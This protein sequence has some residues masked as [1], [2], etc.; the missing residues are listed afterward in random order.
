MAKGKRIQKVGTSTNKNS[1][2]IKRQVGFMKRW[3]L[4]PIENN[5]STF[6]NRIIVILSSAFLSYNMS[7]IESELFYIIG[8]PYLE[9]KY[10]NMFFS[11]HDTDLYQF[12]NKL[13]ITNQD[14]QL[15]LIYL[16]ENLLNSSYE[17]NAQ[18]IAKQISEAI[19]LSGVDVQL[20]KRGSEYLFYPSGAE[21]LDMK[22]VNDTLNWLEDYPKARAQFH[23]GLLLQ[24]RHSPIRQVI[25]QCG[26]HLSF[27]SNNIITMKNRLKIKRN[28]L[29]NF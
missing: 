27:L 28:N 8:S 9:K 16:L 21:L 5:F 18:D 1:D 2:I 10:D 14:N 20:C 29:G 25:V 17:I 15:L 3:N 26:L 12:L 24:Q 4:K 6:K 22:V 19:V 7:S 11:F 23:E 13:D